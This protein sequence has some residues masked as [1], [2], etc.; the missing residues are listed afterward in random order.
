MILAIMCKATTLKMNPRA[1]TI[2]TR[3]STRNPEASSVYSLSNELDDPPAPALRV[4]AGR[5]LA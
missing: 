2:T 4:D 1:M 3:G 5:S